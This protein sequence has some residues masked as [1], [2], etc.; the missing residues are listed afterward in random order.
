MIVRMRKSLIILFYKLS[1]V[2]VGC[3]TKDNLQMFGAFFILSFI[4]FIAAAAGKDQGIFVNNVTLNLNSFNDL[5]NVVVIYC[6]VFTVYNI[7]E[8]FA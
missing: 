2:I 8:Y 5:W 1:Q 4:W 3:P 6:H 7:V